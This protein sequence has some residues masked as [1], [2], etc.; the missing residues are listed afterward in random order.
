MKKFIM[1]VVAILVALLIAAVSCTAM[2]GG[3]LST[4]V[5]ETEKEMQEGAITQKQFRSVKKG[6][7]LEDV[8]AELGEPSDRQVT[9][10]QGMKKQTCI[11]Y[12]VE[13]GEM[14]DMYQFCFDGK[15]LQS[16]SSY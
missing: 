16:K 14:L 5:D 15:R 4:A 12:P 2:V 13:G 11:Y 7:L 8:K 6:A 9:E 10:M 3:A 1:I